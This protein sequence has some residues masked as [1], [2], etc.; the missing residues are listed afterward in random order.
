MLLVLVLV[1]AP[2][3]PPMAMDRVGGK[4]GMEWG[5]KGKKSCWRGRILS[6]RGCGG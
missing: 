2:A 6:A 4:L 3:A 1:S 5:R